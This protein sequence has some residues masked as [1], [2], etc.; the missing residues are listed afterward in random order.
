LNR[1]P[2]TLTE[3]PRSK[4]MVS[5]LIATWTILLFLRTKNS[6]GKFPADPGYDLILQARSVNGI[7]TF[8][9]ERWPYFYIIPRAL[10]DF[11]TI[12]P[13]RFEAVMLGSLINMVWIGSAFVVLATVFCQTRNLVLSIICGSLLVHSPVAMESS[14]GSFGNVKWP[15]TVALT[16]VLSEP[17]FLRERFKSVLLAVFLIGMSTP[18]II[19]CTFPIAYL[20]AKKQISRNKSIALLGLV[21]ITTLLQ[22]LAFGGISE[23]SK[24]WG[25]SKTFDIGGLGFFWIYGQFAPLVISIFTIGVFGFKKMK[26]REVSSFSLCLTVTSLCVLLSSLYLGGIAD[27]YFVAPLTLSS[28]ALLVAIWNKPFSLRLSLQQVLVLAFLAFSI[29]PSIKWFETG[30]YLSSGPNWSNEVER[31]RDVCDKGTV[32]AVLLGVSPSGGV[33]IDCQFFGD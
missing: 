5:S 11:V 16:C 18:M 31:A 24:G 22:V 9:I 19:F 27:R 21:S 17:T 1:H 4:F 7:Q 8:S 12:W 26:G 10:I 30:W 14:L 13:M 23:A 32:R 6:I 29:I 20:A 28:V 25:E 3:L 2:L 33:E 15:L